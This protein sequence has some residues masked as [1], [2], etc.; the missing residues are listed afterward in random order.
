[1]GVS[2]EERYD[3]N[4]QGLRT[5]EV[6]AVTLRKTVISSAMCIETGHCTKKQEGTAACR[7]CFNAHCA[8]FRVVDGK[9][10]ILPSP[11]Q[12]W[13][14][15]KKTMYDIEGCATQKAVRHE[16]LYDTEGLFDFNEA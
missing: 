14:V 7:T 5:K 11:K 3:F 12:F 4:E 8:C 13:P 1:M 10:L 9:W 16:R 2:T 6:A 15:G